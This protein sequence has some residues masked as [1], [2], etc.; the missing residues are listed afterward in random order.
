MLLPFL[1]LL[2]LPV[3]IYAANPSQQTHERLVKLA[4]E[5]N[6]VIKL[7]TELFNLLTAPSR[8]W[9]SSIQFTALDKRRRCAPCK[10]VAPLR[11]RLSTELRIDPQGVRPIL[12]LCSE[13]LVLCIKK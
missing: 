11:V 1:A 13:G 7:D 9:S 6:G 10:Y 3:C 8:D 4:A 12:R 5:N 2:S